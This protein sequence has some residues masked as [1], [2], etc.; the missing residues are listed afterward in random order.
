MA[1]TKTT[2]ETQDQAQ[3]AALTAKSCWGTCSMLDHSV[4]TPIP[5]AHHIARVAQGAHHHLVAG[6][7][8][9]GYEPKVNY[10]FGFPVSI[11]P[12]GVALD[13]PLSP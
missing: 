8:T 9:L 1:Q 5:G 13:I 12:G 11:A 2:L 4:T 6:Y 10:F 3:I 7:G